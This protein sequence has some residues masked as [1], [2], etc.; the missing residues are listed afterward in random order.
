MTVVCDRTSASLSIVAGE[1]EHLQQQTMSSD[2]APHVVEDCLGIVQLLSDGTVWKDVAYDA[3]RGLKLRVFRPPTGTDKRLPVVVYFH[4]GGFCFG[5]FEHPHIHAFCLRL[6]AELPALV[7]SAVYRLAP[8]H[9]LPAAI[10]DGAAVLA[11]L[12]PA[13]EPWL[14]ESADLTRVFVSGESAGGNLAHHVAVRILITPFFVG[15]E[16]TGI[17]CEPPAGVSLTVEM[18]DQFWRMSLPAGA[19]RDHPAANPLVTAALP[20]V[21]VVAAGRDLLRDRVVGY[22]ER[23]RGMGKVVELVGFDAEEHGFSVGEPWGQAATDMI[24]VMKRFVQEGA[25]TMSGDTTAPRVVDD[26][27]GVIQLLSD[28]TVVRSDPSVLRPPEHFPDVPGVQWQDV[29][30]DAAHGLKLRMY[31]PSSLAPAAA[32]RLPVLVYFHSGGFCLGTFEQPNFHTGCLRLASEL[33]AVVLSVDYRLGPEHRPPAAIDDA[34]STLSWLRAQAN[35]HPWLADESVDLARVFVAGESSGANMSHHVAVRHGSGQLVLAPPLRVA[36]HVLVTPYFGGAERTAAE[37]AEPLAGAVFTPDMSDT[38]WRLSLPAGAT[39]DHPV[40][41]PFGPGSPPLEPVA[42]PPVLVVSAGRDIL[43]ERVLGYAVRLEEMGKPVEL[44]VLEEQDHAFFSRQAWSQAASEL[45]RVVKRFSLGTF[46][47][48]SLFLFHRYRSTTPIDPPAML[49]DTAA[50]HVVEDLLGL[51]RLLSDGSVVRGGEAV[52]TKAEPSPSPD[53][54]GVQWKDA[55]Y[56]AARGLKVR[57]YRPSPAAGGS[58]LPVLVHFHG[59]GYCI[60]S[61]NDPGGSDYFR[62]RL[63][64]DLPA[65]VLSVQYRLAPE[66]RLPAAINDGATFL[67]WLRGQAADLGGE[68]WL[69]ESADFSRTFLTGVS[70]GANLAHHLAVQVGSGEVE[71]APARLAGCVLFSVFFGGVERVATETD[72]PDGVSLTVAMSDQLWRMALPVG[73]T[74]DDP[75]ANPFGPDSPDLAAV[76]LPPVLVEAPELDV[77]RDHVLRYAARLEEMGKAVE[78]AEFE[79]QQHGFSVLKWDEANEE[80]IRIVKRFVSKVK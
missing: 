58:K 6:A 57:L 62:Q 1:A 9:R 78:L 19:T 67:A 12:R 44:V 28:G 22:A 30:Y 69:T 7:L 55:V 40:A 48:I 32:A 27:R 5:T 52:A 41:N 73:A 79:G 8:E 54:P 43:H 3:S 36:G 56:D 74:R 61:Y 25:C 59:G 17:E 47:L 16:R 10:D 68:P 46:A 39:R 31:R 45:I 80:L 23:L 33:P 70:A 42:F 20:P 76:A 65:L 26:Y 2:T 60:G 13:A 77:L 53:V 34:A 66:H 35:A 75:V 14:A 71:L 63:A 64:A 49:G 51:V 37:A 29:V 18:F 50:P 24:R 72:P 15:V 21:L 38:M 4:G 11:W